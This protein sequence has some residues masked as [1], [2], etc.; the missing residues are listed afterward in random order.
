MA[1]NEA[2]GGSALSAMGKVEG[3]QA[4]MQPDDGAMK[5]M[6][7]GSSAMEMDDGMEMQG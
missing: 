2:A 5:Q 1:A 7:G 3:G 6:D 4:Y